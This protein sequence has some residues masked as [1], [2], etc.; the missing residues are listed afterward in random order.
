MQII[1]LSGQHHYAFKPIASDSKDLELLRFDMP[2][3]H[4]GR[5]VYEDT[6]FVCQQALVDRN[7]VVEFT[8]GPGESIVVDLSKVNFD[9]ELG[10]GYVMCGDDFI[11]LMKKIGE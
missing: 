1:P 8:T 2:C 3:P 9:D 5:F 6:M 11:G 10:M 7:E 4:M